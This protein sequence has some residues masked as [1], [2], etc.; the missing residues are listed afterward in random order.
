MEGV[1]S[2]KLCPVDMPVILDCIRRWRRDG[3]YGA[4][5]KSGNWVWN[6]A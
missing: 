4:R 1:A 5:R 6:R 2:H 3:D